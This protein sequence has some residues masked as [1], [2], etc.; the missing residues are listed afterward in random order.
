MAG[1]IHK[2]PDIFGDIS[3]VPLDK[4]LRECNATRASLQHT[5]VYGASPDIALNILSSMVG[6]DIVPP[7]G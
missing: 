7:S 4:V 6:N 1:E 5:G 3:D 2:A